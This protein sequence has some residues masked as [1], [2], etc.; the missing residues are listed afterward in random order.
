MKDMK[1]AL[2]NSS[3]PDTTHVRGAIMTYIARACEYG[4]AKYERANYM[5]PTEGGTVR[6]NFLRFGAYLRSSQSHITKCLDRMETHL[7][8][9]PHLEDIEGM[10]RACFAADPD[11]TPGAKVGA[12]GLPHIAHGAAG[13]MMAIVQATMYGLLPEDPG[14]PW[15][16]TVD[17]LTKRLDDLSTGWSQVCAADLAEKIEFTK[18]E[19]KPPT[20]PHDRGIGLACKECGGYARRDAP[21]GDPRVPLDTRPTCDHDILI[22][23]H[24][25][26]CPDGKSS[27]S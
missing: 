8:T 15:A 14:Q 17:G 19:D 5:R 20:C 10:M 18:P 16:D 26:K 25:V 6:E 13:I 3:K 23:R 2:G 1:A 4:S 12:S 22:G 11:V 24:C 27:K 7:A 9:D 21:P